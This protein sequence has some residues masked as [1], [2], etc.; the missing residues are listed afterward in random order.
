[1]LCNGRIV[2][3]GDAARLLAGVES[4]ED[5]EQRFRTADFMDAPRIEDARRALADDRHRRTFVLD[6]R[7]LWAGLTGLVLGATLAAL[8]LIGPHAL[9]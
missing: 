8:H 1:M 5:F 4:G 9:R 2:A 7:V 3:H 6:E